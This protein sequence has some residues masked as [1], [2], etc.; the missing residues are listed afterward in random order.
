[1]LYINIFL[2]NTHRLKF[3]VVFNA[4]KSKIIYEPYLLERKNYNGKR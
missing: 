4:W 1:M 3:T 2:P